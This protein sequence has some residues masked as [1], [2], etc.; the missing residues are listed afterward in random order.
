MSDCPVCGETSSQND[1]APLQ[2]QQIICPRCGTFVLCGTIR[3]LSTENWSV[4]RRSVFSHRLRRMQPRDGRVLD[5]YETT[6]QSLR[7]EDPLPNVAEQADSLV[8]WIGERQITPPVLLHVSQAELSA[9]IGAAIVRPGAYDGLWWLIRQ[10]EVKNFL[11]P[12]SSSDGVFRAGLNFAGWRRF[13][14][15]RRLRIESR[16]AFMAMKF[17]DDDLTQMVDNS[18]R[19]AVQRAGFDLRLLTDGQPAGLIDDQM[20][21]V[22][23]TSRFVIADLT[24]ANNGAYWEAGFAEGLGRPVIYTCRKKEWDERRVHFDTNHLVTVIW[25]SD[26]PDAASAKLAATIRATLPDE[27]RMNDS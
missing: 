15:L 27:A 6:F 21:V 14:E 19:P 1:F 17:G 3:D 9:W 23:R 4:H 25:D 20:R 18:F 12:S 16:A 26:Q 11:E 8:L 24:H 10:P 7:L 22:I 5:I 13:E 2:G